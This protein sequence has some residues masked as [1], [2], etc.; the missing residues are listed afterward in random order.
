[1][2]E[3]C[4]LKQS[5]RGILLKRCSKKFRKIPMQTPV[6]EVSF[7]KKLQTSGCNVIKKT[8]WH[9]CFAENFVTYQDHL[10][11]QTPPAAASGIMILYITLMNNSSEQSLV[12]DSIIQ[13][14]RFFILIKFKCSFKV[15]LHYT[16][17]STFN[18]R[19]IW[20]M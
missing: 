17:H 11:L 10:F 7:L 12:F 2:L 6:P 9:R 13:K 5:P 19:K 18:Y 14:P 4:E 8:I 20:F 1:M 16:L 3:L 15:R